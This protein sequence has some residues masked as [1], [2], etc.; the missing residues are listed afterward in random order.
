[1]PPA[2]LIALGIVVLA[3]LPGS[4]YTWAYERQASAYG[5]TLADRTLRF[6]AV[7]V[8]FHLV[9]GWGEYGFYRLLIAHRHALPA[10]EFALGWGA[11]MVAVAAPTIGGTVLGG[12]YASRTERYGWERLRRLLSPERE[13]RLL[14]VALGRT[15]A[16]RA[17]DNLFSE[18]PTAYLRIR[19]ADDT[20]VGGRFAD[21]SY[22]G[23]FPHEGDL[24]LEEAWEVDQN[25]GAFLGDTG[26]GISLYVPAGQIRWMEIEPAYDEGVNA[27]G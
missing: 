26:L 23:G 20:W 25:S 17:W 22:A 12:L 6:V 5:V 4:M 21:E 14:N 2:S 9:F 19:L 8:I 10:G 3:V 24:L 16:P 13:T 11:V 18:R 15:P 7:S 27:D 1:M